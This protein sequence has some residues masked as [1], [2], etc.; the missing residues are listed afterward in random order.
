M[1]L[2]SSRL[3]TRLLRVK[4][5]SV[6]RTTCKA[7][8]L[9]GSAMLP[10]NA[11]SLRLPFGCTKLVWRCGCSSH[12]SWSSVSIGLL[13]GRRTHS[14]AAA[15]GSKTPATLFAMEL[16]LSKQPT[17]TPTTKYP[18]ATAN[19]LTLPGLPDEVEPADTLRLPLSCASL[20]RLLGL[21]LLP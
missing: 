13:S 1:S 10:T 12:C 9:A 6:R 17:A 15:R 5:G 19:V 4:L 20:Y 21:R 3:C 14:L 16:P 18:I 7:A 8:L 11:Q 2:S